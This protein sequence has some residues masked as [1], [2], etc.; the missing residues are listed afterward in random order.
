MRNCLNC[1]LRAFCRRTP[2]ELL[3]CAVDLHFDKGSDEIANRVLGALEPREVE[4]IARDA[5][6][7]LD[8]ATDFRAIAKEV[9]V[10]A[11]EAMDWSERPALS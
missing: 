9:L 7:T 2:A 3:D 8:P 5:L 1:P 11:I 10:E 6:I 4:R